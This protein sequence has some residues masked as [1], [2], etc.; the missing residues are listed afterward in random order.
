MWIKYFKIISEFE[1]NFNS[2][3][4]RIRWMQQKHSNSFLLWR[5]WLKS[6]MTQLDED[7]LRAEEEGRKEKVEVVRYRCRKERQL[8]LEVIAQIIKRWRAYSFLSHLILYSPFRLHELFPSPPIKVINVITLIRNN[9][10][11]SID[12]FEKI[13]NV[14]PAQG[15]F[16]TCIR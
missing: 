7:E 13:C 16:L 15:L 1:R 10:L 4:C 3:F 5:L 2:F 6:L 11:Y 12:E 14:E 8:S 9:F